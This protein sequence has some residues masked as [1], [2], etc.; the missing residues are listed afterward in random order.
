MTLLLKKEAYLHSLMLI[1]LKIVKTVI[2]TKKKKKQNAGDDS[3]NKGKIIT[4]I[5]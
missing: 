3:S 4:V 1:F 2:M 5:N